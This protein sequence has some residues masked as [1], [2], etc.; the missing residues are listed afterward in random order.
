MDNPL[1][2]ESWPT[3]WDYIDDYLIPALKEWAD[4]YD[5]EAI[6]KDHLTPWQN[7]YRLDPRYRNPAEYW[8]IVNDHYLTRLF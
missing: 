8:Q 3:H 7:R 4:E 2:N 5:L 6:A 1:T